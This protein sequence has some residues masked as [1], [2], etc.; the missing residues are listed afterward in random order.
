M[1]KF[2]IEDLLD[3]AINKSAT[4]VENQI[5]DKIENSLCDNDVIFS[6]NHKKNIEKILHKRKSKISIHTLIAVAITTI[7]TLSTFICANATKISIINKSLLS[8]LMSENGY[9]QIPKDKGRSIFYTKDNK[10]I[11]VSADHNELCFNGLV[12][13]DNL[14][15][16]VDNELYISRNDCTKMLDIVDKLSQPVESTITDA[17]KL[18]DYKP[19]E[20]P[21]PKAI[22]LIE[23]YY[24]IEIDKSK[25]SISC[26]YYD[27]YTYKEYEIVISSTIDSSRYTVDIDANNLQVK[28]ID[29]DAQSIIKAQENAQSR[30]LDKYSDYKNA[31]V[32]TLKKIGIKNATYLFSYVPN[33]HTQR[34]AP[35][36]IATVYKDGNDKYYITEIDTVN[37]KATGTDIE[38]SLNNATNYII[39]YIQKG[40][41]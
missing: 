40:D 7:I 8:T 27:Y 19:K 16:E 14:L 11:Y 25:Y 28:Y 9:T 6:E 32:E 10:T 31:T 3:T 1:S 18:I 17:P 12:I 24:D 23:E 36:L 30:D 29:R 22:D 4:E 2:L 13:F 20:D 26:D 34:K 15:T 38:D 39:P 21:V 5:F 33:Y 41:N 35:T 37:L